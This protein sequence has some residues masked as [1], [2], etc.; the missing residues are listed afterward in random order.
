MP[1]MRKQPVKGLRRTKK[2]LN[3]IPVTIAKGAFKGQVAVALLVKKEAQ[4][5][6]PVRV[7]SLINSAYMTAAEA[8]SEFTGPTASRARTQTAL[9]FNKNKGRSKKKTNKT[10]QIVAVGYGVRYAKRVHNNP[11]AGTGF[12]EPEFSV[13]I[14]DS[15]TGEH[16]DRRAEE[17]HSLVGEWKFLDKGVA[18]YYGPTGQMNA[19]GRKIT[20]EFIK[21]ELAKGG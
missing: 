8:P 18:V 12:T 2:K 11:R 10:R 4:K 3:R 6:T 17:E 5:R 13:G 16:R 7:G 15:E 19:K 14:L 21:K 9:S 1:R 20:Q